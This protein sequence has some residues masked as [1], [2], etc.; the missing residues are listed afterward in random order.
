[1]NTVV[2]DKILSIQRCIARAREEYELGGNN[3]ASD[4]T[5]QDAAILN[6]LRACETAIDLANHLI[7]VYQMG[8]PKSSRE[9]FELL[10]RG[11]VI[12]H[13]LYEKLNK[14]VGFRNLSVHTYSETDIQIVIS[15]ITKALDDLI[16]FTDAIKEFV[17]TTPPKE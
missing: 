13:E 7:R 11:K 16:I 10:W 2:T 12:S 5:H 3:F 1:M 14:M 17:D 8:V 15:V 4:F 9:S 6:V